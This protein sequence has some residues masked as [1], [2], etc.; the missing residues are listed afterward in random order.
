M[1]TEATM[2][3]VR[4]PVRRTAGRRQVG[5][6][7]G[8]GRHHC[9]VQVAAYIPNAGGRLLDIDSTSK[10]RSVRQTVEGGVL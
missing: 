10:I 4:C 9:S 1:N 5:L 3:L 6:G 8:D 2:V 7:S